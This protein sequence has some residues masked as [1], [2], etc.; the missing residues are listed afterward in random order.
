VQV[1][2]LLTQQHLWVGVARRGE[3]L[4]ARK[5]MQGRCAHAAA[6]RTF[7]SKALKRPSE[8][9]SEI[10]PR[11]SRASA[12][13]RRAAWRPMRPP[14]PP[15]SRLPELT[16]LS[17]RLAELTKLRRLAELTKLRRRTRQWRAR[18]RHV[19]TPPRAAGRR[20]R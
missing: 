1:R 6:P 9:L 4:H 14:P 12:Y 13:R 19:P 15:S 10:A 2:Q 16:K 3:R 20:A 5:G 11:G 18:R 8:V 7:S 17:S